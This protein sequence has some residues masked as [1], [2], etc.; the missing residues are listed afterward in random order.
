MIGWGLESREQLPI[1][2]SFLIFMKEVINH[3][4]MFL[5]F[6]THPPLRPS[7]PL[8]RSFDDIHNSAAFLWEGQLERQRGRED[9]SGARVLSSHKYYTSGLIPAY[10]APPRILQVILFSRR[11]GP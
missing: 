1:W 11:L 9:S 2:I 6:Q 10:F 7:R 3:H 5:L 8:P 4:E